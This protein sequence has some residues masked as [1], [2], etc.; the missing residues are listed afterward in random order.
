MLLYFGNGSSVSIAYTENEQPPITLFLASVN[1]G[2][3]VKECDC[4]LDHTCILV[5]WT[6]SK[7]IF[8]TLVTQSQIHSIQAHASN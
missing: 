5:N 2:F 8:D 4:N 7:H 3:R 6:L 1:T